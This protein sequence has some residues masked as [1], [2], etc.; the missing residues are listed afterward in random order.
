MEFITYFASFIIVILILVSIHE[1]GHYYAAKKCG[2]WTEVFS[3]GVGPEIFSFKDST[4]TKFRLALIP[5]GG[6]VKMFGDSGAASKPSEALL[7]MTPAEK[8]KSFYFQKLWKKAIIVAA[9]PIA[10]FI[11]AIS[12]ISIF[13]SFYGKISSKPIISEIQ[14]GSAAIKIGL[15]PN[16]R[17]LKI[18]NINIKDVAD[19]QQ[20]IQIS[21]NKSI[22]IEFQRNGK[23]YKKNIT[24]KTEII[25]DSFDNEI[26]VGRIGIT[27]NQFQHIKLGPFDS[28]TES[29]KF[30]YSTCALTLKAL[31]N[32]I[33][34]G[35]G[36][37]NMGGPVKIAQYSGKSVLNG[38]ASFFWLLAILSINLGFINLLPIP[39]LD[40]GHL[41]YYAIEAITGKKIPTKFYE[42]SFKIGALFLISCMIYFTVNDI[43]SI[44]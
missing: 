23:I 40:G 34:H 29:L 4:G 14:K 25:K 35:I 13:F 27:F 3:I 12:I 11:L 22:I 28:F 31:S 39:M 19:V 6:Y 16:D 41:F 21:P 2:V 30:T 24:P 43:K 36:K 44:F 5:I 1:F 26:K 20:I 42:I 17:I 32:L 9:G 18:D 37:E 15:K 33:T 10:N 7:K 38:Y 8:I